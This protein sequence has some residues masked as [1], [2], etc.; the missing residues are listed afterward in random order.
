MVLTIIVFVGILL[1]VAFGFRQHR[2]LASKQFGALCCL[3]AKQTPQLRAEPRAAEHVDGKVEGGV[4]EADQN[5]NIGKEIN[6]L[7]RVRIIS[8]ERPELLLLVGDEQRNDCHRCHREEEQHAQGNPHY[9][10]LC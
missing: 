8:L 4:Q 1:L 3:T 5:G 7:G 10:Q 2:P 6:V 9:I